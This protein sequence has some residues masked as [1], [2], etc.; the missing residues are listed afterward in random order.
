MQ[1][2]TKPQ[3]ITDYIFDFPKDVQKKLERIR[4]IARKTA[5]AA[6]EVISYG[7]P[8]FK[9]NGTYMVYFAGYKNHISI[10][11]IPHGDDN[12]QAEI[13]PFVAGKGTLQ[14]PLGKRMPWELVEKIIAQSLLTNLER[15]QSKK[16]KKPVETE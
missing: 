2:T 7:V 9:L 8:T 15:T 10:Y 4:E 14:F 1:K 13:K 12:F 3:T 6:E 11:P 16:P 5:P